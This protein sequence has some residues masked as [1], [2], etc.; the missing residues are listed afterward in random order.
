MRLL[1]AISDTDIKKAS[2][3]DKVIAAGILFDKE[4]LERGQSTSNVSVLFQVAE[5]AEKLQHGVPQPVKLL[6]E[7]LP[8][9]IEAE[10]I[11]GETVC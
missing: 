2:L 10:I 9:S 6:P 7:L 4:R 8:K 3:R 5:E 11:D 1:S